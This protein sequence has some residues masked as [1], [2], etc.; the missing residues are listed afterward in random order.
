M[1]T[2]SL[3]SE[4]QQHHN[5]ITCDSVCSKIF[6]YIFN[7][8][9]VAWARGPL[10]II[11]TERAVMWRTV[12]LQWN[13]FATAWNYVILKMDWRSAAVTARL[14]YDFCSILH[15]CV[16]PVLERQRCCRVYRLGWLLVVEGLCNLPSQYYASDPNILSSIYLKVNQRA[17]PCN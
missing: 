9:Q 3:E 13:S 1:I 4:N 7:D 14:N 8:F 10:L 17:T 16:S 6:F 11:R 15:V 2:L 5:L 12:A